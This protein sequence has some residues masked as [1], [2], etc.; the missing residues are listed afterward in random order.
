MVT[1]TTTTSGGLTHSKEEAI[2]IIKLLQSLIALGDVKILRNTFINAFQ[3]KSIPKSDNRNYLHGNFNIGGTV[4]GRMSSNK[5]NLQNMP[6]TGT[7][8]AKAFKDCFSAPDGWLMVGADF[9]SLE[10]RIAALTTKDSQKLK[11]YTDGYD[12]HCLRAYAYFKEKMPDI[13]QLDPNTETKCYSAKVGDT[14]ICFTADDTINYLGLTY[15]GTEFH[16]LFTNN[17]L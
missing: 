17:K 1:S 4:S 7:D 6:S 9:A 15:T 8:Y 16:E 13:R 3:T 5:P 11:L 12:G 2:E 10:D 14:Y